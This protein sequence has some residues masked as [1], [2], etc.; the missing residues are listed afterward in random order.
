MRKILI[1]ILI[2]LPVILSAQ[3]KNEKLGI[4]EET[5]LGLFYYNYGDKNKANIEVLVWGS[6]RSPGKYLIPQGT[7]LIDLLTLCGGPMTETKLKDIRLVRLKNDSL[8]VKEDK[9]INLDYN[10]FLWEDKISNPAKFNPVLLP[11]DMVIFPLEQKFSLRD[12]LYLILSIT[13]TL[14]SITTFLVTVLR[15]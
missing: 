13:S 6:I 2:L 15:K 11:G 10:D 12:N 8:G 3:D 7:T 14:V 9:V 5:K 4:P 1:L